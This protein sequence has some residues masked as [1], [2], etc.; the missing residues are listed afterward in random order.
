ML[1]KAL[2]NMFHY[3]ENKDIPLS[4]PVENSPLSPVEKSPPEAAKN[5]GG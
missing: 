2:P 4:T 5:A 1:L 3:L